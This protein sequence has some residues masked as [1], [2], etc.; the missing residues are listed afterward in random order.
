[1]TSGFDVLAISTM[2]ASPTTDI[3]DHLCPL[4]DL[5]SRVA[6]TEPHCPTGQVEAWL[7]ASIRQ[8]AAPSAGAVRTH[9]ICVRGIKAGP[10]EGNSAALVALPFTWCSAFG[11]QVDA[12]QQEGAATVS[13][14]TTGDGLHYR[15]YRCLFAAVSAL[16]LPLEC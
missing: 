11:S 10:R 16:F 2:T 14:D 12:E 9:T 13:I 15:G 5:I 1:M 6:L 8:G 7:R 4:L 3:P